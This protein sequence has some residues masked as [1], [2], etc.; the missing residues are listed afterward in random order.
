L[1]GFGGYKVSWK[2]LVCAVYR[3]VC[4]L[5]GSLLY[6][7]TCL[8][9]WVERLLTSYLTMEC[10]TLA[11]VLPHPLSTTTS[12]QYYHIHS[13]LPHLL[14]IT[15]STQ[16]YHIHSVLPH[17]LSITTST[18]YYHIYSVLSHQLSITTST[19]YYHIHSVLPHPL[20]VVSSNEIDIS[21]ILNIFLSGP[22]ESSA[23]NFF[24]KC[25]VMI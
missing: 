7:M 22:T 19:Q 23:G 14:S 9:S 10:R 20:S 3:V 11:P 21:H 2:S 4:P 8:M 16:Y 15:T 13:V 5:H 17:P 25:H 6:S 24:V 1:L 12:T 18:Q